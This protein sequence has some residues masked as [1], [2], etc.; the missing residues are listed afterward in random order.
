MHENE[1]ESKDP[2]FMPFFASGI[3]ARFKPTLVIGVSVY[4][5]EDG[6]DDL[7]GSIP[8]QVIL[9]NL[10]LHAKL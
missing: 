9:W 3:Q 6:L 4:S 10:M 7:Y 2:S 8:T 5:R 1:K